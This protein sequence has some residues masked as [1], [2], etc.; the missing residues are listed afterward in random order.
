MLPSYATGP[1]SGCTTPI[2]TVSCAAALAAAAS[3]I[4]ATESLNR[5]VSPPLQFSTQSVAD[6]M[7]AT[8]KRTQRSRGPPA[9]GAD[10]RLRHGHRVV[11]QGIEVAAHAA[12]CGDLVHVEDRLQDLLVFLD[13]ERHQ[14]GMKG[15]LAPVGLETISQPQRFGREVFVVAR[16]VD[17]FVKARV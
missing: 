17:T 1:V 6:S 2:F 5:M 10:H 13:G 12:R 3:A 8:V 11:A 7:P 16:D 15:R 4:T 14:P 9:G